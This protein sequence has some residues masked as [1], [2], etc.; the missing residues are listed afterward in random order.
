MYLEGDEK[1]EHRFETPHT[2]SGTTPAK[3]YANNLRQIMKNAEKY[4]QNK[5]LT[6]FQAYL[7]IGSAG[8]APSVRE[9]FEDSM[10]KV[11]APALDGSIKVAAAANDTVALL[12]GHQA[13]GAIIVGTGSNILVKSGQGLYQGGGQDWVANDNGAGFWI[14]LQAIR[15][16]ARDYEAGEDT[17][18]R[19]RFEETYTVTSESDLLKRF[20]SLAVVNERMKADIA[21]F[22]TSVC[23]AAEFGDQ[24]A[25][26][27]VK[28]EAEDFADVVAT[29]IRRRFTSD[30][31]ASGIRVV[32]CGS[33]L[34]ND[35]YNSMFEAQLN[36]RL[37]SDANPPS[38]KWLKVKSGIDAGS[39]LAHRL[40]GKVDDL[41]ELD[42]RYRPTILNLN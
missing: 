3:E 18:L 14:G 4:C 11:L 6:G 33:V 7:F 2:I 36:M 20:R 21:R 23:V 42:S 41:L 26:N 1:D 22:A 12:F 27:I 8:Y 35:F 28:A 29:A 40:T 37:R 24:S 9:H 30:E 39:V 25:Q 31:L 19:S 32:Q 38:I 13:D 16:V 15:Q 5:Q 34:A 10:A 17:A